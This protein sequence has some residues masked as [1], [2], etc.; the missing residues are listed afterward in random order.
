MASEQTRAA[1]VLA[2][3]IA[4]IAWVAVPIVAEL[5]GAW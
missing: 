1:L 2:A 4:F 5:M 3:A